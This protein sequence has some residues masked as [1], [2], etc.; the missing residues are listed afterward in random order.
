MGSKFYANFQCDIWQTQGDTGV[1]RKE[2]RKK[3]EQ[4]GRE[5]ANKETKKDRP[6]CKFDKLAG[7]TLAL[8]SVDPILIC[9][10]QFLVLQ[11]NTERSFTRKE[12]SLIDQ[13]K[14]VPMIVKRFMTTKISKYD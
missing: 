7:I 13:S 5:K 3:W 12:F 6:M 9:I 8:Y 2:E 1:E 11:K 4:V 14:V 10:L